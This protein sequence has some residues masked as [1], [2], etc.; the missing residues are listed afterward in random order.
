MWVFRVL[1]GNHKWVSQLCRHVGHLQVCVFLSTFFFFFLLPPATIII[2]W[3]DDNSEYKLST[4]PCGKT[5]ITPFF[6][7][8]TIIFDLLDFI[9]FLFTPTKT[10]KQN[11]II[12]RRWRLLWFLRRNSHYS[13]FLFVHYNLWLVR[14]HWLP[15]HPYQN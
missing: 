13:F 9:D 3:E 5:A 1:A 12:K 15:I 6:F 8:Y 7:F 4:W 10:N 14:L 11:I 2:F